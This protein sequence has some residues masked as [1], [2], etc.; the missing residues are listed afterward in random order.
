MEIFTLPRSVIGFDDLIKF[1]LNRYQSLSNVK[2]S[3]PHVMA[4]EHICLRSGV[5]EDSP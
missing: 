4:V 2:L 3:Q 5:V 1:G